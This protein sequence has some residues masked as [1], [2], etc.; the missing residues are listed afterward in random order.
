MGLPRIILPCLIMVSFIYYIFSCLIQGVTPEKW[1]Y[2]NKVV[3]PPNYVVPETGKAKAREIF[4]AEVRLFVYI[5]FIFI[6][7]QYI[8]SQ[9]SILM[10]SE[11]LTK[12]DHLEFS[13]LAYMRRTWLLEMP[14]NN[15]DINQPRLTNR[16]HINLKFNFSQHY[17]WLKL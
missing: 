12:F 15:C 8:C 1:E 10:S 17:W 6:Q 7:N 3:W 16:H 2:L 14:F 11:V 5:I 4:I 13:M 9:R